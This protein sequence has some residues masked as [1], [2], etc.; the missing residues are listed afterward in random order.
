MLFHWPTG[1]VWRDDLPA[2]FDIDLQPPFQESES[3]CSRN[4]KKYKTVLVLKRVRTKIWKARDQ[5]VQQYTKRHEIE[6]LVTG[7][8]VT[9][10]LPGGSGGFVQLLFQETLLC[11]TESSTCTSIWA[12]NQVPTCE[13]KKVPRLLADSVEME[14]PVNCPSKRVSMRKIGEMAVTGDRVLISCRC[15]GKC[16]SRKCPYVKEG[17]RCSVH[18]HA[19][20][21]NGCGLLASLANVHICRRE[22]EQWCPYLFT[23]FLSVSLNVDPRNQSL[24]WL[25]TW[26]PRGSRRRCS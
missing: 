17:K 23:L 8:I 2:D 10:K 14:V 5:M 25:R 4:N 26:L 1:L 15:K 19:N 11:S 18:C 12:P 3:E 7:D 24:R 9:L 22:C 6:I 13:L 16:S 20:G 21:E